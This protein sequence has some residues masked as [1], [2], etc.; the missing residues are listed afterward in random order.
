LKYP[1]VFNIHEL[2]GRLWDSIVSRAGAPREY[3]GE[4]WL[5]L[6]SFSRTSGGE[7]GFNDAVAIVA[8]CADEGRRSDQIG[9]AGNVRLFTDL[10]PLAA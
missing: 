1:A 9:L 10:E 5:R 2:P 4:A 8:A 6:Q 3:W 7:I